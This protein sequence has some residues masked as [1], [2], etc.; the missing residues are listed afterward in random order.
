MTVRNNKQMIRLFFAL[1]ICA[2][3]YGCNYALDNWQV[4]GDS[5]GSLSLS[6]ESNWVDFA[7]A[8]GEEMLQLFLGLTSPSE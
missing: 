2:G 1:V 4:S 7:A 6:E 3:I 5:L 8:L